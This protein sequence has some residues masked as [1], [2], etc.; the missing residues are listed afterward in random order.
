MT[1]KNKCCRNFLDVVRILYGVKNFMS[2]H[3]VVRYFVRDISSSYILSDGNVVMRHFEQITTRWKKNVSYKHIELSLCD[4]NSPAIKSSLISFQQQNSLFN[5]S[6][7][8]SDISYI[9]YISLKVWG[10]ATRNKKISVFK[11][12]AKMKMCVYVNKSHTYILIQ[13]RKR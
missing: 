13:K 10:E 12:L 3:F 8:L 1:I 2:R 5:V 11:V 9:T 7:I 6:K 4:G